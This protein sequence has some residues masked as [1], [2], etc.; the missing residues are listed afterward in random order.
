M[1]RADT[2]AWTLEHEL[3]ARLIEGVDHATWLFVVRG[4]KKSDWPK[5]PEPVRHP[6]RP[7][8]EP[9][10][11]TDTDTAATTDPQEIGRFFGRHMK[12]G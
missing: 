5:P 4:L 8:H 3:L 10:T 2:P 7:G 9:D 12:G 6:D 1:A 11:D